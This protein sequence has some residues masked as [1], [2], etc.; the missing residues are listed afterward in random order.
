MVPV[1]TVAAVALVAGT[2]AAVNH[3]QPATSIGLTQSTLPFVGSQAQAQAELPAM[4]AGENFSYNLGDLAAQLG[5]K[6][7]EALI[8]SGEVTL[9]GLPDGVSY[10]ATTGI[11]SGVPTKTGTY[12]VSVLVKG[13]KA[14]SIKVTV[15]ADGTGTTP[16]E[17]T[18]TGEGEGEGTGTDALSSL[19][20]DNQLTTALRDILASLGLSG[21]VTTGSL[22]GGTPAT[23]TPESPAPDAPNGDAS[24]LANV[25]L[26]SLTD[27]VPGLAT[28]ETASGGNT[29]TKPTENPTGSGQGTIDGGSISDNVPGTLGSTG[30]GNTTPGGVKGEGEVT[31]GSQGMGTGS[32]ALVPGLTIAGSLILG[33]ALLAALSSG[34]TGPTLNLDG[35]FG[36]L[37]SGSAP[38]AVPTEET[39]NAQPP[40]PDVENGR[41]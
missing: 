22:G 29:T 39:H 21:A 3:D 30:E 19:G 33:L 38:Q 11:I 4:Q 15:N 10:D 27:L 17:N 23:T 40:G 12:D 8:T 18:G 31:L 13:I 24:S 25:D 41:G 1:A 6:N 35:A 14:A 2:V 20:G 9:E 37:G 34:S 26:G 36:S 16:G 7:V 28:L 5:L 32:D